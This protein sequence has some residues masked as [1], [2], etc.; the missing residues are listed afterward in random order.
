MS[1]SSA[2]GLPRSRSA[3]TDSSVRTGTLADWEGGART[4]S[5]AGVAGVSRVGVLSDIFII[6]LSISVV[7]VEIV[8]K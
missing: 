1:R 5:A 8:E 7:V 2:S 4:G 3:T 6:F